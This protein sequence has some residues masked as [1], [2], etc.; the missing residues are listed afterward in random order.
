[1]PGGRPDRPTETTT[2]DKKP[3]PEKKP[4]PDKKPESDKKPEPEKKPELDKKPEGTGT[5]EKP[6][7]T[8]QPQPF[9]DQRTFRAELAEF[10]R[11]R[12]RRRSAARC[13]QTAQPV[14]HH[15]ELARRQSR[16]HSNRS[17]GVHGP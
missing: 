12:R 5:A 16:R 2:P 4:E 11:H 10:M 9:R 6:V 1:M 13:W 14:D 3:E 17:V 15:T 7:V 8:E